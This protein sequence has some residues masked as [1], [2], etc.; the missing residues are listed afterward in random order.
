MTS[1]ESFI[2]SETYSTV[3]KQ[4]KRTPDTKVETTET[5]VMAIAI[6]ACYIT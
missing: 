1:E 6:I 5:R 4:A 3:G 2:W